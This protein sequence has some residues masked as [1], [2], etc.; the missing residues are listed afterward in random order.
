MTIWKL[1]I[2]LA[3]ITIVASRPDRAA[4]ADRIS[5]L[6]KPKLP[7][8]KN[9]PSIPSSIPEM[10]SLPV[11]IVRAPG[12]NG[13][14]TFREP[15][16]SPFDLTQPSA[17]RSAIRQTVKQGA[18]SAGKTSS[19]ETVPSESGLSAGSSEDKEDHE[20]KHAHNWLLYVAGI[21]FIA[22]LLDWLR[23]TSRR[24]LTARFLAR[25]T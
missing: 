3:L 21:C 19:N 25:A 13:Q 15:I 10:P 23:R 5:R 22:G 8:I 4:G 11:P 18:R 12:P 1:S 6:L 16:V 17:T 9:S 14:L 20:Q 24:I 7:S 2:L